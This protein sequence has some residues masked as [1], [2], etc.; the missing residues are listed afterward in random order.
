MDKEKR[1]MMMM[2][3][4]MMMMTAPAGKVALRSPPPFVHQAL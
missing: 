3:M 1:A 4:M 2:M